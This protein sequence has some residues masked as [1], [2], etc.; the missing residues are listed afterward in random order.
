M[1][2]F[3]FLRAL[4]YKLIIGEFGF[5]SY[6]GKPIFIRG[7]KR[8]F[9]GKKVRIYPHARIEILDKLSSIVIEDNVSIG[10][11]FHIISGN[12]DQLII[13][14]DTVI[15]ANVFIT[16]VDHEYK[17]IN[18][19][20]DKQLLVSRKSK[21]GEN[22]FIGYG[23]VIQAGTILGKQCIVGANAVVRGSFPDY[24]VIAGVP[25]K[26]I[27]RYNSKNKMWDKTNEKGDF[28]NAS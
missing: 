26:I 21:I 23:A 27:K 18:K 13:G 3:W 19:S 24:S 25:A 11:N 2:I 4:M 6:F 20:L 16:N 12:H 28:L 10:Q 7:R 14:R 9:F 8:F 1:K 15:S 5:P 17:I 22:C